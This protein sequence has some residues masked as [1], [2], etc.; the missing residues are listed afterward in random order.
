MTAGW[1]LKKY[2][3][4]PAL[5]ESLILWIE[6]LFQKTL[7]SEKNDPQ[8]TQLFSHWKKNT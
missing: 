7:Y 3:L 4:Y 6:A 1:N 5:A 2:Q 8:M